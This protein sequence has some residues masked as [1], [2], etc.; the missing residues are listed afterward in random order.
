M[1]LADEAEKLY[2]HSLHGTFE[3]AAHSTLPMCGTCSQ[4]HHRQ[5]SPSQEKC[6]EKES[7]L[8]GLNS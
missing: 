8:W 6:E 7:L 2:K 3:E 1:K 4:N 5:S